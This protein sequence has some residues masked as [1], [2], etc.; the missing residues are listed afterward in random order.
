MRRMRAAILCV[1]VAR[2]ADADPAPERWRV[3]VGALL[4]GSGYAVGAGTLSADRHVD[5]PWSAR[6]TGAIGN[7]LGPR[8]DYTPGRG[9]TGL[10][11]RLATGLEL[12]SSA[13]GTS[14]SR[15]FMGA[16]VGIQRLTWLPEVYN[17]DEFPEADRLLFGPLILWRIGF[18]VGSAHRVPVR[19][20]LELYK[21]R[22]TDHGRFVGSWGTGF[23][24]S[25][26]V[27]FAF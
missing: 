24:P 1:L 15:V 8:A 20:S 12:R 19:F 16:D 10:F 17:T 26:E 27:A 11:W 7:N 5:G 13:S 9:G 18:E 21:W 23:G 4:Q 25:I 22:A 3:G 6:V 2:I 14:G